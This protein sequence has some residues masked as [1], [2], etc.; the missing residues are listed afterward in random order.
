MTDRRTSGA[1][2]GSGD[3]SR[4]CRGDHGSVLRRPARLRLRRDPRRPHHRPPRP[5]H[6]DDR[7][8]RPRRP[9]HPPGTTACWGGAKERPATSRSPVVA[10]CLTQPRRRLGTSPTRAPDRQATMTR[11]AVLKNRASCGA[12]SWVIRSVRQ[13]F[14]DGGYRGTRPGHP[15]P[16]REGP[17]RTP[18]LE[19]GTQRLPPQSPRPRRAR[20]RPHEDLEDPA[21]LPPQGR[22]RPPRHARHRPPARPRPRRVTEKAS[23]SASTP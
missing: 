18:G 19:G 11:Q 15:A 17:E 14:A 1:A 6:R 5:A 2:T 4:S 21:R 22:R 12:A 9:Q 13:G 16:P 7:R 20:L 3:R 23:R 10:S 8:L